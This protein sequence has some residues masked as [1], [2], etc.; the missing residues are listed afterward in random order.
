MVSGRA[1][2]QPAS[3]TPAAGRVD[4]YNPCLPFIYS[5]TCPTYLPLGGTPW[6]PFTADGSIDPNYLVKD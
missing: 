5:E 4:P 6:A 3:A 2:G 1:L